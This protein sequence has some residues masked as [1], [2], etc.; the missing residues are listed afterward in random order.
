MVPFASSK[1]AGISL[2]RV[3]ASGTAGERINPTQSVLKA[4]LEAQTRG[5]ASVTEVRS[6]VWLLLA[7][8]RFLFLSITV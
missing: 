8:F 3:Q 5:L 7:E 2:R 6:V 4:H 1:W